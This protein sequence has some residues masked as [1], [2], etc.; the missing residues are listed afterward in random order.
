MNESEWPTTPEPP[1]RLTTLTG[2]PSSFS[3]RLARMR[4]VAS[5]PPPAPQGTTMVIGR[6]GY[7]AVAGAAPSSVSASAARLANL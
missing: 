1:V 5:V 2:T 3:I 6:S 4:P 7:A